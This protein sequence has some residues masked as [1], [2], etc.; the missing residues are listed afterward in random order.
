MLLTPSHASGLWEYLGTQRRKGL[1][2]VEIL[3]GEEQGQS[4]FPACRRE[5]PWSECFKSSVALHPAGGAST[6]QP[7]GPQGPRS[8]AVS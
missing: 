6:H 8:G 7:V 1:F 2:M 3:G 5:N 4:A